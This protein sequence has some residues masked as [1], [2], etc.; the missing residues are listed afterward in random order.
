MVGEGWVKVRV[1]WVGGGVLWGGVGGGGE[2]GGEGV[3][4]AVVGV[5]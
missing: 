1:V 3:G 2:V 5:G 4:W